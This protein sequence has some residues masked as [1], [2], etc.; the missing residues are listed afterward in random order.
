M[1]LSSFPY[2]LLLYGVLAIDFQYRMGISFIEEEI[3]FVFR[4]KELTFS[5]FQLGINYPLISRV[6][7]WYYDTP[8]H[9]VVR[10]IE[11][12]PN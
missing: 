11:F 7:N 1:C 10:I 9:N 3:S 2:L 5:I 8:S 12:G 6:S 4:L